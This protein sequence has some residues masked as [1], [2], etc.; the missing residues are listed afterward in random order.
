MYLWLLPQRCA[1]PVADLGRSIVPGR[2]L[3]RSP[4]EGYNMTLT[5]CGSRKTICLRNQ[6]VGRISAV[7]LPPPT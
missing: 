3:R 6:E 1:D 5:V 2:N 4:K 7:A